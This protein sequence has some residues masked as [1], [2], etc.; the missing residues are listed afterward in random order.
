MLVSEKYGK[1]AYKIVLDLELVVSQFQS[2]MDLLISET[3]TV[4][5]LIE[6]LDTTNPNTLASKLNELSEKVSQITTTQNQA[7]QDLSSLSGNFQN[8]SSSVLSLQSQLENF[9]LKSTKING[10]PLTQDIT[11]TYEDVGLSNMEQS[12]VETYYEN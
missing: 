10:K 12:E 8:L 4:Q 1:E 9:A 2:K 6:N 11:L 3:Q 7:V 5:N